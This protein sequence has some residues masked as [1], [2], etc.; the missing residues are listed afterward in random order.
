[1][2]FFFFVIDDLFIKP[3]V[4]GKLSSIC[5]QL[6]GENTNND[7]IRNAFNDVS[8]NPPTASSNGKFEG[9]SLENQNIILNDIYNTIKETSQQGKLKMYIDLVN[10]ITEYCKQQQQQNLTSTK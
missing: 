5:S 9:L 4:G 3:T 10:K 1:M 6:K 8:I 2:F 7:N